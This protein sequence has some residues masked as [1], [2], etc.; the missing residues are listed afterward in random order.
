MAETDKQQLTIEWPCTDA[1]VHPD[2]QRKYL[3]TFRERVKSQDRC[4]N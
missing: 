4:P 1:K 3:G 2:E